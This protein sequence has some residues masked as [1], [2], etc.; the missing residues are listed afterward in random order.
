MA[1]IFQVNDNTP[2]GVGRSVQPGLT[3]RFTFDTKYGLIVPNFVQYLYPGE[4]LRLRPTSFIRTV[5]PLNRP[6]LSRVRFV[7]RFYK[8]DLRTTFLAWEDFIKGTE[9]LLLNGSDE[10]K[11]PYVCNVSDN[12]QTPNSPAEIGTKSTISGTLRAEKKIGAGYAEFEQSFNISSG[13][14]RRLVLDPQG[15]PFQRNSDLAIFGIHELGDYLDCAVHVPYEAGGTYYTGVGSYDMLHRNAFDFAAY[16]LIYS[17]GFR[18]PRVQKRIDDFYEMAAE[19][20]GYSEFV[21]Y[22]RAMNV[23]GG[24]WYRDRNAKVTVRTSPNVDL[25]PVDG[26]TATYA[27]GNSKEVSTV[28]VVNQPEGNKAI[29]EIDSTT[30][31]PY[32]KNKAEST[33]V[34]D[35]NRTSWES[36]E[37]WPLKSGTNV[38]MLAMSINDNGFPE[39]R[40]SAISLTRMR[41]A[42]WLSDRFV[43]ATFTPQE[44][45]EAQIPVQG[46][47]NVTLPDSTTVTLSNVNVEVP[48]TEVGSVDNDHHSNVSSRVYLSGYVRNGEIGS[49]GR[50]YTDY[51]EVTAVGFPTNTSDHAYLQVPARTV[52]VSGS[53]TA[54]FSSNSAAAIHSLSISPSDFRFYMQLQKIKE[55]QQATDNRYKSYITKFFGSHVPDSQLDRPQFLGGYVQDLNVSEVTQTSATSESSELGSVAG[56][57]VDGKT[58]RS[59]RVHADQ[60]C[61]VMGVCFIMPDTEYVGGQNREFVTETRFDW[62]LPQFANISKQAIYN[63]ELAYSVQQ[64]GAASA[65]HAVFGYEPV[66]NYLRWSDNRAVG[67]F[68]DYFNSTGNAEEFKPWIVKR[69]FGDT[70]DFKI[71]G[72]SSGIS[73]DGVEVKPAVPTLSDEFLSM[74]FGVDDSNFA[75]DSETLYPFIVDSYF[76]IRAVR[77]IPSVGIARV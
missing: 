46:S 6:Q 73:V 29:G 75:V 3:R 34:D 53:S 24:V 23:S 9:T 59:I 5:N 57:I 60:H 55:M 42:N 18:Q 20:S 58:G 10:I 36:V 72:T 45:D 21:P 49:T 68:R 67:V 4:S 1:N 51:N 77:K 2:S 14:P 17:F 64:K 74:R 8:I 19:V 39:F 37:H 70:L 26:L 7:Q 63:Y 52:S 16:Q 30:G 62:M 15:Y 11:M 33:S 40:P 76:D 69:Y 13:W 32:F 66:Y 71:T 44:G 41:Y 25:I 31:E 12:Y 56:K 47:V 50:F 61:I 43:T 48:A 27:S 28:I 38:S 22:T 54:Q 35:I 65:A